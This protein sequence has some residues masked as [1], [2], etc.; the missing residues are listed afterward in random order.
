MNIYIETYGCTANKSDASL[1]KGVLRE[2][3]HISVKKIDEADVIIILTCT[4]INTTEQRML[5]RLKF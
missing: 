1:I 4:V 2:N 5:S 3:N